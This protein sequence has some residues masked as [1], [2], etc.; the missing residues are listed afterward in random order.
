MVI[1]TATGNLIRYRKY[2]LPVFILLLL[3]IIIPIL[4][5]GTF[6]GMKKTIS[7]KISEYYGGEYP[8]FAYTDIYLEAPA[9]SEALKAEIDDI[10]SSEFSTYRGSRLAVISR[11]GDRPYFVISDDNIPDGTLITL[12]EKAQ[13]D[14]SS[15]C[16]SLTVQQTVDVPGDNVFIDTAE[17]GMERVRA[18]YSTACE[19]LGRD[20]SVGDLIL[21]S[22]SSREDYQEILNVLSAHF[23]MEST[24]ADD[25]LVPRTEYSDSAVLLMPDLDTGILDEVYQLA[26]SGYAG[27]TIERIFTMMSQSTF[28]VIFLGISASLAAFITVRLMYDQRKR[29]YIT[30]RL[31]GGSRRKIF[32]IMLAEDLLFSLS[33]I[34]LGAIAVSVFASIWESRSFTDDY[35]AMLFAKNGHYIFSPDGRTVLFSILLAVL[36]PFIS[37][38]PSAF[39]L[40]K[41]SPLEAQNKLYG[42]GR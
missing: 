13:R 22:F 32:S 27:A 29:E 2:Y 5:S 39:T 3:V 10:L 30:L 7:S 11:L 38:L 36:V 8:V 20:S 31:L 1:R 33:V 21:L 40:L 15:A 18:S 4:L 24:G 17:N 41:G 25:F 14:M 12:S 23:V 19:I 9:M 6:G 37:S 34:I 16:P 28:I 26:D 35:I 42:G